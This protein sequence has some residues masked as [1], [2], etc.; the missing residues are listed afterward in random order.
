M[1]SN[2]SVP[3]AMISVW[4][5]MVCPAQ[6]ETRT[7]GSAHPKSDPAPGNRLTPPPQ[8]G[9]ANT[10]SGST[11]ARN[12]SMASLESMI[13]QAMHRNP[14]IRL[15]EAKLRQ[16]EAELELARLQVVQEITE[17]HA[18][19]GSQKAKLAAAKDHY[20]R[21]EKLAEAGS[22]S[23]TEVANARVAMIECELTMVKLES[24][25]QLL[26]GEGAPRLTD[27]LSQEFSAR[28]FEAKKEASAAPPAPLPPAI[29]E[30]L[31]EP[32]DLA[33]AMSLDD[34]VAEF[35]ARGV[36][37]IL[38]AELQALNRLSHGTPRP[39]VKF[40]TE[41]IDL[42]LVAGTTFQAALSAYC[43]L[44]GCVIVRRQY[45]IYIGQVADAGSRADWIAYPA[46][47]A[48]RTDGR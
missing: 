8:S 45:G 31:A 33:Q 22:A 1:I 42:G 7:G 13:E 11:A 36:N 46:V 37:T 24:M 14:E 34:I 32:T 28:A 40:R 5:A 44:T 3:V 19:I 26:V 35:K 23:S 30:L 39:L 48:S 2:R 12:P 47:H 38:S 18:Q 21:I 10:G 41:K 4:L 9:E 27:R 20:V 15:A 16:A 43:D 17:L 29:V 25:A 6:E